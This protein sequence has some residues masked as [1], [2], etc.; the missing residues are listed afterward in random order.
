MV[1]KMGVRMAWE[2][3]KLWGKNKEE[4]LKIKKEAIEVI[5]KVKVARADDKITPEELVG[6]TESAIE[7][8]ESLIPLLENLG[9]S[10]ED[11]VVVNEHH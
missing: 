3:F 9:D 5:E 4:L 8:L 1:L 10:E 7:L 11:H 2:L 6:I